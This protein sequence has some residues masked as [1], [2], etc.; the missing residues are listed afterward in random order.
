MLYVRARD[1][2]RGPFLEIFLAPL[3]D[4]TLGLPN[5]PLD[6]F[7]ARILGRGVWNGPRGPL[8]VAVVNSAPFPEPVARSHAS[9]LKDGL[10]ATFSDTKPK[11]SVPATATEPAVRS[12]AVIFGVPV[13]AITSDAF[14]ALEATQ[15]IYVL[16]SATVPNLNHRNDPIVVY[17]GTARSSAPDIF[18][19][20]LRPTHGMLGPAVYFGSFWKAFRFATRT[21]DYQVREGAILRCLAFWKAVHIKGSHDKPCACDRC[22]FAPQKGSCLVDHTGSWSLHADAVLALPQVCPDGFMT[23]K[24]EEYASPDASLVIIDSYGSAV[25]TSK[26]H[27]PCNRDVCIQ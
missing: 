27:E 11:G 3:P 23:V 8:R 1:G 6:K 10:W 12:R 15:Q 21:Q 20:G 26:H 24:N 5:S 13:S 25:S 19:F 22:V 14:M 9:I 16:V 7:E 4:Q 2:P 17:H 18:K